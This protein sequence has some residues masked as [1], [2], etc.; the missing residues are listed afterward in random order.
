MRM[1]EKDTAEGGETGRKRIVEE[2]PED[3]WDLCGR[4]WVGGL[5]NELLL[6]RALLALP[7][8]GSGLFKGL[9]VFTLMPR[10]LLFPRSFS[11]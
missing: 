7:T 4:R 11:V 3:V 6:C 10:K 5:W 9:G 1:T 8:L 2:G